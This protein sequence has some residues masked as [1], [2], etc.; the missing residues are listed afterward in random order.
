MESN[1]HVQPFASFAKS[2]FTFYSVC[3]IFLYV[4]FAL[5]RVK[6]FLSPNIEGFSSTN[7]IWLIPLIHIIILVTK[8]NKKVK[9]ERHFLTKYMFM[10]LLIIL[11][12]GFRV[13]VLS[14]FLFAILLFLVPMLLFY[15]TS[16]LRH[17]EII[18][19]MKIIVITNLVYSLFSIILVRN[20][21]FFVNLIGNQVDNI[22][23]FNQIRSPLMLGSSI[24]V[25]Y[26]LNLTLPIIFYFF[27]TNKSLVWKRI[28]IFGI[29]LNIIATVLLLS[30]SATIATF[31]IVFY[32]LIFTRNESKAKSN[33]FFL[34][35]GLLIASIFVINNYDISRI[36]IGFNLSGTSVSARFEALL[37]GMHIFRKFPFFGSGMGRFYLRRFESRFI[38]VDGITGLIDPHNMF[39]LVM[40]EL[41]IL[42]LFVTMLL[43]IS[44]F[45]R[46]WKIRDTTMKKTAVITLIVMIINSIGGSHLVNEISFSSIF[47]IYMGLFNFFTLTN[48]NTLNQVRS[49][50]T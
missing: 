1:T 25:S 45:I 40:S 15:S 8:S 10:Y 11:V 50:C 49:M 28:S 3:F 34:V 13:D 22:V 47:W 18:K 6:G 12:G 43:F 26:F 9:K 38:T 35:L 21:V 37:L 24:T 17:F 44:L 16:S 31:F 19:L 27:Y 29:I 7:E 39:V 2:S 33:V 48:S 14:Q 23:Y 20:Y 4:L 30:R 32:Y 41:G 42:G 5:N 46:F 36:F